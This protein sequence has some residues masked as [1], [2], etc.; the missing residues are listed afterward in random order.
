MTE[1]KPSIKR[2][3]SETRELSRS[4][5][6]MTNHAFQP[7]AVEALAAAFQ[8]AWRF[9]SHDQHFA[10]AD[11]ALLK[12]RLAACLMESSADGEHDPLRLANSAVRRMRQESGQKLP[13][14]D[15][16]AVFRPRPAYNRR[17]G[18]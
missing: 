16:V 2:V 11:K 1:G 13:A 10:A 18:R 4:P 7:E 12:R 3:P 14:L 17:P 5:V 9:V 15:A 6:M 8:K